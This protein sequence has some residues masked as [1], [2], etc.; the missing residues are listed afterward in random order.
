[1][2]DCVDEAASCEDVGEVAVGEVVGDVV[3]GGDNGAGAAAATGGFVVGEAAAV[4][5]NGPFPFVIRPRL[6]RISACSEAAASRTTMA[7]RNRMSAPLTRLL[8]LATDPG[9]RR[10]QMQRRCNYKGDTRVLRAPGAEATIPRVSARHAKRP[11]EANAE[12]AE[13]LERLRRRG[14][15]RTGP[16][17]A[18]L[19]RLAELDAPV[20]HA[21]LADSLQHLGFDRATVYRNLM[22]LAQAGLVTRID[23]GD[24][25]WR[26]SLLRD[27][28]PDHGRQHP[29]LLCSDCGTV[30]CLPDVK[31][32]ITPARGKKRVADMEV[33]LK[34][35]CARCDR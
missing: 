27:G 25:V 26:F 12:S 18:A 1:V 17:M 5:R 31:V 34:G 15:R 19:E 30:V 22:D 6:H 23:M 2:R 13:L 33:Q 7:T 20:S 8:Y 4:G 11:A 16:R 10:S 29:H 9:A 21:E 32:K 24:H 35:P 14:L 28:E 3:G